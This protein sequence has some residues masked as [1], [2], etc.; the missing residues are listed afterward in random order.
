MGTGRSSMKLLCVEEPSPVSALPVPPALDLAK[1]QGRRAVARAKE[2]TEG[3]MERKG[4]GKG[5]DQAVP[6]PSAGTSRLCQRLPSGFG[7]VKSTPAVAQEPRHSELRHGWS[8]ATRPG[9]A[10]TGLFAQD[11]SSGTA[12]ELDSQGCWCWHRR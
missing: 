5:R 3:S 10:S 8:G 7:A 6:S 4:W 1:S 9:P 12:G 11:S 2:A